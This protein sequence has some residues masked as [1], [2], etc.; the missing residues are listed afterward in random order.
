[1]RLLLVEDEPSLAVGTARAL[2]GEGYVVDVE[3]DGG[4]GLTQARSVRYDLVILDIMLPTTNGYEVC[5][6]LRS[7]GDWTPI[8]FLT[9]KSGEYDEAEGLELGADDYLTKPFSIVVLLARVAAL[10]RRPRVHG[11]S[12]HTAGDIRIDP[13]RHRCW[14]GDDEIELTARE[15]EV[16]GC[17]LRRAGDVVGKSELVD[18]VWGEQFAGNPNIAE[19]Y[20]GHLRRKLDEPYGRRTIHTVRG[21]GYRLDVPETSTGPST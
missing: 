11:A 9:A 15:M 5:R 19:V 12:P 6:L 10:L 7:D 13:M 16:L 20:V 2:R 18:H 3:S 21:V 8:L 14:V 1:M 17:L 4:D